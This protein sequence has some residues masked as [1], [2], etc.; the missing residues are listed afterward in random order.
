MSEFADRSN[1]GKTFVVKNVASPSKVL[2]V[3]KTDIYPNGTLDLMK[4]NGI[5]EEDIKTAILKGSL[6]RRLRAGTLTVTAST[7]NFAEVDPAYAAVLSGLGISPSSDASP[8]YLSVGT[9]F[10]DATNGSDTNAG[11]T[12]ATALKT[13]KELK[14]R[15][16]SGYPLLA[17]AASTAISPIQLITVYI[18]SNMPAT[19][20]LSLHVTLPANTLLAYVGATSTVSSGTFSAVTAQARATNQ[21]T[22]VTDA[23]QTW[24]SHIGKRIRNT[25]VGANLNQCAIVA[26]DLGSNV[27]RLSSPS[28]PTLP[29]PSNALD[30]AAPPDRLFQ[31]TATAGVFSSGDTYVIED[32]TT[33]YM[34]VIDIASS[35]NGQATIPAVGFAHLDFQ[36]DGT[37]AISSIRNAQGAAET[38]FKGCRFR[39]PLLTSLGFQRNH[40]VGC[41]FDSGVN[42][43]R[44]TI[45]FQGGLSRGEISVRG[46]SFLFTAS[47]FTVQG[48]SITVYDACAQLNTTAC[49]DSA[50]GG[51]NIGT[52]GNAGLGA[53]VNIQTALWGS[54]NLYGVDILSGCAMRHNAGIIAA[55]TITGTTKQFRIAGLTTH[56]S[57]DA[58]GAITAGIDNQWTLIVNGNAQ[59]LHRRAGIF[60][61]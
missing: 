1:L 17:G 42:I 61:V 38:I 33:V 12:A 15:I 47:D 57:L 35:F 25:T 56:S 52:T 40:A 21:A 39:G 31:T 7:L 3:F 2:S 54:G 36:R 9:W 23:L 30:T 28:N 43:V 19:D 59:A 58:S 18:L 34:D 46:G 4:L 45:F 26:K 55:I 5:S 37:F 8:S 32:L 10:I 49:F 51:V 6:G 11:T 50:S 20:P 44:S 14:R 13:N 27:A 29:A 22:E 41:S 53:N 60:T 24:A 16:G 48:A